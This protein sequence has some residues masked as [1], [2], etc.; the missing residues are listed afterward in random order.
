MHAVLSL[1]A[2]LNKHMLCWTVMS[3]FYRYYMVAAVLWPLQCL[4]QNQYNNDC[5]PDQNKTK[6]FCGR[7]NFYSPL[8]L[9]AQTDLT[10]SLQRK[11][12]K[13]LSPVL[14]AIMLFRTQKKWLVHLSSCVLPPKL[15]CSLFPVKRLHYKHNQGELLSRLIDWTSRLICLTLP[16][17]F[18]RELLHLCPSETVL[19]TFKS[20][21]YSAV[22][23]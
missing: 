2:M 21:E 15:H 5:P 18:R 10:S 16:G 17:Q 6:F 23:F 3:S 22:R 8:D 11:T 14:Q 20:C 7:A 13:P 12:K 1:F 4:T 19:C 9:K